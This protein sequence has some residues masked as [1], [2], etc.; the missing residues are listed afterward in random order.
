MPGRKRRVLGEPNDA[1]AAIRDPPNVAEGIVPRF[2]NRGGTM[3][4]GSVRSRSGKAH[5]MNLLRSRPLRRSPSCFALVAL[6]ALYASPT[7][8]RE[9]RIPLDDQKS[10]AKALRSL[11]EATGRHHLVDLAGDPDSMV[12]LHAAWEHGKGDKEKSGQFIALFEKRLRV[13]PPEWWQNR[14]KGVVVYETCH[15]IPGV[16]SWKAKPRFASEQF[17]IVADP[18][19]AGFRYPVE[20]T[21]RKTGKRIWKQDIWAVGRTILEG[22]GVHQMELI[23][24]KSRLFVF[25]AESHGIYAEAFNLKD[26]K[27]LVRFCSCY[28]F[29]CSEEWKLK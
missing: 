10:A 4:L 19:D 20:V 29:N 2:A 21:D 1:R 16:V 22:A 11:F 13:R 18:L 15:Y 12:A 8:A 5:V 17:D 14:L 26:G 24:S 28:W 3:P 25:G 23:V 9:E 7:T 6:L 27:P